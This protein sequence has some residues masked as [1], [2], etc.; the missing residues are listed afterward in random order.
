[1]LPGGG[2]LPAP[3]ILVYR[4]P[5]NIALR[6]DGFV[7]RVSVAQAA[8]NAMSGE[9][10]APAATTPAA[11]AAGAPVAAAPTLTP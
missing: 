5:G 2:L 4:A 1:L 7:D 8:Q 3:G 9:T 6:I 11:P 10:T